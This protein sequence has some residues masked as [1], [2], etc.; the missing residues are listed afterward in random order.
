MME[1]RE[2]YAQ[3]MKEIADRSGLWEVNGEGREHVQV[4]VQGGK[5]L[6]SGIDHQTVLYA[7]AGETST[8]S[9]VSQ[10]LEE[11]PEVLLDQAAENGKYQ[12]GESA[13]Y[14]IDKVTEEDGLQPVEA[15]KLRELAWQMEKRM[16]IQTEMLSLTE[17]LHTQWVVNQKG[18]N[19]LYHRRCLEMEVQAGG[20]SFVSSA[21]DIEQL[22]WQ[23]IADD[24]RE[25]QNNQQQVGSVKAGTYRAVLSSFVM[26]K[27]WITGWQLFSGLQY[28]KGTGAFYGKLSQN[29]A[30][31]KVSLQ[32]LPAMPGSGYAFPFDCEG[33]D[34]KAVD[35][36]KKGQFCS[37]MH[38]LESAK[39]MQ[40][41][42]TGNAG[43]T[44]GLV[45][46]TDIIVTPKNFVFVPGEASEEELLAQL[47]D[48]LYIYDAWDEFH[49]VNVA[50]GRFSFP[51]SAVIIK[52]GKRQG[53]ARGMTMNGRLQDLLLNVELVGNK[54]CHM[55]LLMHK[56]YE[57]AAPAV[58]VS[59]ISVT[60]TENNDG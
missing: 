54:L 60:G 45:K 51:C 40:M 41:E 20:R 50:S 30:S 17:T 5:V 29:I 44:A 33:S 46:G 38:N 57:V 36:I 26:A 2:K 43:R 18:L 37:L 14:Q 22:Q 58:L 49:A 15:E 19:R 16:P 4:S 9:A 11:E 42:P 39:K 23:D 35:L 3:Y 48:G 59:G 53:G 52:D 7:R 1:T 24:M 56:T 12:E 25:W 47:G 31:E 28:A 10:C 55:P 13:P 27:F 21:P 8:G 34:S 6:S 32:D